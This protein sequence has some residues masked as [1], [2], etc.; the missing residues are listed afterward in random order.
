MH[1]RIS[2]WIAYVAIIS[3]LLAGCHKNSQ[4][5]DE[6]VQEE[7]IE[8]TDSEN[9]VKSSD[10]SRQTPSAA[11]SD[12]EGDASVSHIIIPKDHLEEDNTK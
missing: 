9:S 11:N 7:N 1:F 3:L 10:S 8:I 6:R 2:L 4:S 5:L 12:N